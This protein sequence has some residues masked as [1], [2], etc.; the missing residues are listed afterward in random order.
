MPGTNP[1]TSFHP[2]ASATPAVGHCSAKAFAASN[3]AERRMHWFHESAALWVPAYQ[4]TVPAAG[5]AVTGISS[6]GLHHH[7]FGSPSSRAWT[8]RS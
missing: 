4:S 2:S 8:A 6:V 5:P 7:G 1:V 3:C